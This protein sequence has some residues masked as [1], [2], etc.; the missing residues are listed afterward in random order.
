MNFADIKNMRKAVTGN[1]AK[2]RN[3]AGLYLA[4]RNESARA[5]HASRQYSTEIIER[6]ICLTALGTFLVELCLLI[7]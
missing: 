3:H 4:V 1:P 7:K 2:P 5:S 6:Y